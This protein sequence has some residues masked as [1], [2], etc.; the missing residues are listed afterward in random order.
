MFPYWRDLRETILEAVRG[1]TE[2]QLDWRPPGVKR[3]IRDILIHI[4]GAERGWILGAAAGR[5]ERFEDAEAGF[6]DPIDEILAELERVHSET[7]RL[8]DEISVND[9]IIRRCRL[10]HR[11]DSPEFSLRW[12]FYHVIEHEAHHRG[13]IFMTMRMQGLTPPEV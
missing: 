2:E 13:Q 8:L 12:V 9:L 1:L 4:A 5:E 11:Q 10:R 6:R 3:S 7:E